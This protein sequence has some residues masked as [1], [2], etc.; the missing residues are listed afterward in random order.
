[1]IVWIIL[2]IIAYFLFKRLMFNLE[3]N[4]GSTYYPEWVP[5]MTNA[6]W[7]WLKAIALF[8]VCV[9]AGGVALIIYIIILIAIALGDSFRFIKQPWFTKQSKL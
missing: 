7:S 8:I 4:T 2:G 1:M 3:D 9:I 5:Y 6:T